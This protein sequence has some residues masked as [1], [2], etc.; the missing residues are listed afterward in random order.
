MIFCYWASVFQWISSKRTELTFLWSKC[1]V[2]LLW[3]PQLDDHSDNKRLSTRHVSM[4]AV[5]YCWTLNFFPQNWIAGHASV[6]KYIIKLF[7]FCA[8]DKHSI[9]IFKLTWEI[10]KGWNYFRKKK[11]SLEL[12]IL[13]ADNLIRKDSLLKEIQN[14]AIS[15][16]QCSF[17][18]M[19][20]VRP[21]YSFSFCWTLF[22]LREWL[23]VRF[24]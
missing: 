12:V 21:G 15:W 14:R 16:E 7:I 17:R 18:H 5:G 23:I 10:A 8:L 9:F 19:W 11:D 1:A 2:H 22:I 6:F 13:L 24:E 4:V 20:G 3:V